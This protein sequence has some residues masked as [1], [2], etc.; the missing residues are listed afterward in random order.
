MAPREP[1]PSL[2]PSAVSE[3]KISV[4]SKGTGKVVTGP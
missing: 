4:A 2:F 3:R 1:G